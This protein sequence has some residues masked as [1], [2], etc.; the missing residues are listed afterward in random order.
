MAGAVVARRFQQVDQPEGL[1]QVARAE[2]QVLVVLD[3]GLAVEVD[4]EQLVVPQGLG[5]AVREVQSGHLLVADLRVEADPV[6]P[7]QLVDERQGVADGGQQDVAARL[8]GLGFDREAQVVALVLDVLAQQVEGFLQPVEGGTHVLGRAGLRALAAAPG[9]VD[10][11][12]ELDGQVDVADRLAQRVPAHVPVVG[13]EG[14]VLEHRVGE[15]VRRGH[16]H[17]QPGCV[18]CG[19]EPLDRLLA[20]GVAGAEGDQVVVVERDAVGAELGQPLDALDGIEG[21]PGGVAEG[22]PPLPADGPQAE[23]EPVRGGGNER[24]AG[25]EALRIRPRAICNDEKQISMPG[26]QKEPHRR[27]ACL[28][29]VS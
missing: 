20:G 6:G 23:G 26:R 19:A 28:L 22:V 25:H 13:G 8:V 15:E 10:R 5:D 17:L 16:R 24:V 1:A 12:A 7:V 9:D 3:A 4:V 29:S 14:A 11:G 18:E 2:A 27:N 21:G